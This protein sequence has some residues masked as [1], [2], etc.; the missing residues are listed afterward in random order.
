MEKKKDVWNA[1]RTGFLIE[2]IWISGN[3]KLGIKVWIGLLLW[4]TI[5]VNLL[6]Q[7]S[8]LLLLYVSVLL[9][10]HV[11]ND[12]LAWIIFIIHFVLFFKC[13]LPLLT[14]SLITT[15]LNTVTFLVIL[16]FQLFYLL[17]ILKTVPVFQLILWFWECL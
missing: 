12:N 14:M 9:I 13:L 11:L 10:W 7:F 16:Q 17:Q 15:F 8:F 6:R 4:L 3:W 5:S 2:V 1:V